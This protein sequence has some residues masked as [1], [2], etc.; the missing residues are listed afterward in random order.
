LRLSVPGLLRN[1]PR[2]RRIEAHLQRA[3]DVERVRADPST[4]RVLVCYAAHA[5]L[6]QR[7]Q[8]ITD[9]LDEID[10]AGESR[11]SAEPAPAPQEPKM[12]PK[13]APKIT[14]RMALAPPRRPVVVPDGTGWHAIAPEEVLRRLRSGPAGLTEAEA[15]RRLAVEGANLIEPLQER[16]R[17]SILAGQLNNLP[18]GLLLGSAGVALILGDLLEAAAIAVVVAANTAVGYRLERRQASLL[19]HWRRL[20]AGEA[21]VVRDGAVR[22]IAASD[23]VPGDVITCGV[24]DVVPA[25]ARVLHAH[26]LSSNESTLTGE[27]E[28][29]AKRSAAVAAECVLAERSSMLYAGTAIAR[30]HGR[31]VVVATGL[32]T[33]LAE[34]RSLVEGHAAPPTPLERQL[35]HIGRRATGASVGAAALAAMAGL[36]RGRPPLVMVRNAV[37]LGV[38]AIPEGLPL[39]ATS[40][41]MRTMRRMRRAGMVVRRVAS[42]EA[43]GSVTVICTDKT[44]TVTSNEMRLETLELEEGARP[45]ESLRADPQRELEDPVTLALLVGVLNSDVDYYANGGAAPELSGSSTERALVQAAQRAGCDPK[46]LGRRYPRRAL[47]ERQERAHYVLSLHDAPGGGRLAMVKGAP[48]QVLE[49]CTHRVDGGA[50]DEGSRR[51]MLERNEALAGDGQRVLALGWRPVSAEATP[52]QLANGELHQGFR[53]IGLVGLR[54]PPRPGAADAIRATMKA[55]I[56]PLM[57]TGDQLATAAAIARQLGLTGEVMDGADLVGA[58]ARG[59]AGARERLARVAVLSRVTPADKLAIVQALRAQ[60]EVVAM[61]GDGVN[62]APALKVADVGVAVGNRATEL[63]R[64]TADVVLEHEDL[65]SI[66]TAISEARL[67]Q[68]NLRRATRFLLATNLSEVGLM[69]GGSLIG[70]EPLRPLQL[71][72]VN[73]L[74]D[75]FPALALALAPRDAR[76]TEIL[77]GRPVDGGSPGE[78]L[79]R[80]SWR[81]IGRDAL[82]MA[83]LGTLGYLA[84]GADAAFATLIGGQLSYALLQRAPD[85]RLGVTGSTLGLAVGGSLALQLTGLSL[86]VL[87]GVLGMTGP[88]LPALLGTA[89][90]FGLPLLVRSL[91]LRAPGAVSPRSTSPLTLLSPLTN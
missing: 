33:Q 1:A 61:V 82:G 31:A 44:G 46:E 83:A 52:E 74:T 81:Q 58:L 59:E 80:Q 79:S 87:R 9:E 3:P 67:A 20:E 35:H 22:A 49:L 51:R 38:A 63:T 43:L 76:R 71:L 85:A 34:V 65:R 28:A 77:D 62:D 23:L 27:S 5:V 4:G 47:H 90:G 13:M 89:V 42:A 66:L 12:A 7:L 56:R 41:L 88:V 18:T 17:L 69:L 64:H 55:G 2:A 26:R 39:V 37:A 48:E 16:S 73:L 70:I 14:L 60:G 15:A 45:P 19:A 84:G 40:T 78:I 25:D 29:S 21:S 54:D 72:W 8:T 11:E 86:P 50:L 36:L 24:G 91:A 57:L 75:T 53:F 68:D 10:A 6:P 32:A 30:G